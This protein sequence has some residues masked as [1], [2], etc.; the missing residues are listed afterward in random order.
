[1]PSTGE[2]RQQ[3]AKESERRSRLSVPAFAGGFLYLLSSIVIA[4]TLNNAPTV[5]LLQ[6]LKPAISGVAN[7]LVSPRAA[8]VKFISH[9]ALPLIAG[10]F[11]A[12]FAVIVLTLILLMLLDA[13][14]FRRP[15]TWPATRPLVIVGGIAVAVASLAHQ[16]VSAIETHKFAVGHDLTGHAVEQALTKSTPDLIV[17][18]LSLLAGL[19]LAAGMVTVMVNAIRVGLVARWLGILGMFTALLIF[20]PIGGAELQIVPAFWL[21]MMGM[22][23]G[24]RWPGGDPPAWTDGE[25]RP[26][27]SRAQVQAEKAGL[28]PRAV[29]TASGPSPAATPVKATSRKRRKR[30]GRT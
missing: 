24:G 23:N 22:L 30:G 4:S 12:A 2:I 18:Y 9:K 17:A 16:I 20:L 29:A 7:P 3:V 25:A 28:D 14:K 26:W 15:A 11:L 13:V 21:V 10:S 1:M 8:E 6:G 27:P 19:A 5:G